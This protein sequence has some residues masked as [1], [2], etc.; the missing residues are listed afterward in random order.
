[1][2]EVGSREVGCAWA[3]LK[4]TDS[5]S[6]VGLVSSR[7]SNIPGRS[8]P[9]LWFWI[10]WFWRLC[11]ERFLCPTSGTDPWWNNIKKTT[12]RCDF[13]S[14]FAPRWWSSELCIVFKDLEIAVVSNLENEPGRMSLDFHNVFL[15]NGALG[16]APDEVQYVN[17][18]A[19][20]SCTPAGASY[21][22][23]LFLSRQLR[24]R[25]WNSVDAYENCWKMWRLHD[26]DPTLGSGKSDWG[27]RCGRRSALRVAR[28]G[29][30]GRVC[31]PWSVPYVFT[32]AL[33]SRW[34]L[35]L[36]NLVCIDTV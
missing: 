8:W 18:K 23:F 29:G 25:E 6:K 17:V 7:M 5:R 14:G 15:Q 16:W 1:M 4:K 28:G 10:P 12:L 33:R 24:F 22:L 11:F 21:Y 34:C 9:V 35:F 27:K 20:S 30:G 2:W 13:K 26:W 3:A 31:T 32:H 19:C 36:A